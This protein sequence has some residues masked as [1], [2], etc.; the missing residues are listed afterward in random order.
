MPYEVKPDGSI[1]VE[2]AE[3]ALKLRRAILVELRVQRST[4]PRS[5]G[6]SGRDADVDLSSSASPA[7]LWEHRLRPKLRTL[8]EKVRAEKEIVR[9][10]MVNFSKQIECS[11]PRAWKDIRAAATDAGLDPNSILFKRDAKRNGRPVT[12]VVAGP[13]LLGKA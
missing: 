8:L 9:Q 13:V 2:T 4:T 3:E 11:W 5:T 1:V 10:D 12:L 6:S 7:E